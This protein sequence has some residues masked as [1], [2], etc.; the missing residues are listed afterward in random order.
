MD[1]LK[2]TR[3]T[4]RVAF[5][6]CLLC[7]GCHC[8][9]STTICYSIP[10]CS[11]QYLEWKS[12]HGKACRARPIGNSRGRLYD[13]GSGRPSRVCRRARADA[14]VAETLIHLLYC[15]QST[16]LQ[17]SHPGS[18]YPL[19]LSHLSQ[20]PWIP[21]SQASKDHKPKLLAPI[22]MPWRQPS[23]A[24]SRRRER[25]RRLQRPPLALTA[26]MKS[27]RSSGE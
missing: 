22:T 16:I 20:R 18:I 23:S 15:V 1:S 13:D 7:T 27:G 5:T 3:I 6:I 17:P 11:F 4:N 9:L 10:C 21:K 19:C 24:D 25:R 14:I 8:Y 2:L 26:T 12:L